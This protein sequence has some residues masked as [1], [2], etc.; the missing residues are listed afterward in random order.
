MFS[1]FALFASL[2]MALVVGLGA[3]GAHGLKQLLPPAQIIT[4]ETGVRYQMY[5]SFAIFCAIFLSMQYSNATQKLIF[6]CKLFVAGIV[7]F[8]GSLYALTITNILAKS[9]F[10]WFVAITPIG[11]LCFIAGWLYMAFAI[12]QKK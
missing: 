2:S 7:V 1:K 6:A 4:F 5:H 11:G 12:V 3:F 8:S 10:N 9:G